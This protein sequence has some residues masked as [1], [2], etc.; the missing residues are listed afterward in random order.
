MS[1]KDVLEAIKDLVAKE[2]SQ[3]AL[4]KKTGVQRS[5]IS[6]YVRDVPT[7]DIRNMT[8]GTFFK[9]F[10]AAEINFYGQPKQENQT[11]STVMENRL[12]A[13]FRC[14]TPA[15]QADCLIMFGQKFGSMIGK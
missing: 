9:L 4:A 15:Q 5:Q 11:E 14:L 13:Y 8:L 6:D 3:D 2:G 7:R 1:E 10:P 12:L